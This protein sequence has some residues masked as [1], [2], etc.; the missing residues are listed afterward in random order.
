MW[1]GRPRPRR[2]SETC[3]HR[4]MVNDVTVTSL[5]PGWRVLS[6][7]YDSHPA[8]VL[9]LSYDSLMNARL[10]LM[11]LLTGMAMPQSP[12]MRQDWELVRSAPNGFGG[13][14]DLVLVP[15]ARQRDRQYYKKV[16]DAVCGTRTTCMVKFWTDRTHIPTR[17]DGWIPITDL[18][19]MTASYERFPKYKEPVLNL[20]CWLY[21]SKTVGESDKCAYFPGAKKPPDK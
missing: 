18:A 21:P 1:G 15:E 3:H 7:Y 14:V 13:T 20:A 19:I 6:R 4:W 5:T 2:S 16:A 12:A 17:T 9:H 8:A 10:G 11:L